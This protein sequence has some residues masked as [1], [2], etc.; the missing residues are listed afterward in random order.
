MAR[1]RATRAARRRRARTAGLIGGGLV[2]GGIAGTVLLL[3]LMLAAP[4]FWS[5]SIW[6]PLYAIA[7]PLVGVGPLVASTQRALFLSW[8]AIWIGALLHLAWSA[9]A[10]VLFGLAVRRWRLAGRRAV[11]WGVLYGLAAMAGTTLVVAPLAGAAPL[12][13]VVGWPLLAVGHAMFGFVLGHWPLARPDDFA[14]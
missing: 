7:S 8:P 2:A 6:S 14:R 11:G 5:Q 10:G 12:A 4:L 13:S 3:Y 1:P 9:L